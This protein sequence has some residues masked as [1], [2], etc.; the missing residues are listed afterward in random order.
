MVQP[1]ALPRAKRAGAL[2]TEV[3]ATDAL[4]S[5]AQALA[6]QGAAKSS[7]WGVWAILIAF[8]AFIAWAA[9]A[10]LNEG[11][12]APGMVVVDTKRK[13]VQHQGGGTLKEVLVREGQSVQEGQ[14][15]ARMEGTSVQANFDATRQ[16]YLGLLA[17]QG[18]L[19]AERAG[20]ATICARA[21]PTPRCACT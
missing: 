5:E 2:S 13:P 1:I 21:A 14:L 16:R 17:M 19:Q 4:S 8:G 11:V 15:I 12:P 9:Y 10:P 18:R 7:R 6:P 20:T 3:A